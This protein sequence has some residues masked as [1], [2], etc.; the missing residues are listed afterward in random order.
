M[1]EVEPGLKTQTAGKVLSGDKNNS[2]IKGQK[3]LAMTTASPIN[4]TIM[5]TKKN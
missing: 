2:G 4:S 5:K 3:S 1:P